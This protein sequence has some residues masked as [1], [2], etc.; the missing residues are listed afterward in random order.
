MYIK[1]IWKEIR[2]LVPVY[3]IWY[4]V[5]LFFMTP[6]TL[7]PGVSCMV[8]ALL[9]GTYT[10]EKMLFVMP[11]ILMFN[12]GIYYRRKGANWR[13]RYRSD[14]EMLGRCLVP[15]G[16]GM[17]C[18]FFIQIGLIGIWGRIMNKDICNWASPYSWFNAKYGG[19]LQVS[20]IKVAVTLLILQGVFL[21]TVS[22][23]EY[24]WIIKGGK[25]W[26]L[27]V[28]MYVISEIEYHFPM[29]YLICHW[30]RFR[31]G[32]ILGMSGWTWTIIGVLIIG[33]ISVICTKV[34]KRK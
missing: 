21:L 25:F 12:Y 24:T 3:I 26:V 7:E 27:I 11:I 17:L 28:A 32:M 30:S 33:G 1:Q 19:T 10:N 2:V 15:T 16:I 29:I 4:G 14:L 8:D 22:L 13:L 34:V 31:V 5:F 20:W 6:L 18:M 9:A 23:L